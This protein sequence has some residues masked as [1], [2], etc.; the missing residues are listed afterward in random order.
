MDIPIIC[1]RAVR[2]A[3][4]PQA[5]TQSACIPGDADFTLLPIYDASKGR[6][7]AV[8]TPVAI[9]MGRGRNR[10]ITKGRPATTPLARTSFK[11]SHM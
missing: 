2:Q 1:T 10:A 3:S 7:A 4:V 8:Y 6:S 5:Q 11:L 9:L